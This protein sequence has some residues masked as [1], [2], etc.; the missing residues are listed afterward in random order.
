[1]AHIKAPPVDWL[2]E[3]WLISAVL[4]ELPEI[5]YGA[6]L[7]FVDDK[8]TKGKKWSLKP[9]TTAQIERTLQLLTLQL[10]YRLRVHHRVKAPTNPAGT[11]WFHDIT[12]P[13]ELLA[14]WTGLYPLDS[15]P[16]GDILTFQAAFRLAHVR[17]D[18]FCI[19]QWKREIPLL[20][21]GS[22]GK[23]IN[24]IARGVASAP[25]SQSG[26][27]LQDEAAKRMGI[28]PGI[29]WKEL[30][31]ELQG[32]GVVWSWTDKL[33]EWTDYDEQTR[34]SKTGTFRNQLTKIR[35]GK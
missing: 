19:R 22:G 28:S 7:L 9:A 24:E 26:N 1:M 34:T 6:G 5:P 2:K 11:R 18:K 10:H 20:V 4:D 17:N 32:D 13:A 15:R 31:I 33:I 12:D 30:L 29:R 16:D 25:R 3:A 27:R 14:A 8:E 23:S 21:A 35:L